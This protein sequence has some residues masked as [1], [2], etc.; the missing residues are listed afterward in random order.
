MPEKARILLISHGHPD[1][2]PGGGEIAAWTL[3]QGYKNRP[4]V[5]K[6]IFLAR[7]GGECAGAIMRHGENEYLW[8]QGLRDGFFM[9]GGNQARAFREFAEFLSAMRPNI[10]H[11]HHAAHMGY[12]IL[13]IIKRVLPEAKIYF[14]LHEYIPICHNDGQMLKKNGGLCFKSGLAACRKCFPEFEEGDF[15]QRKRRFQHFFS[16]VDAFFAPSE[17]LRQRYIQWGLPPEKIVFQENGLRSLPPCP[18]RKL[19]PGGKRGRFG[20]FGQITP[21]KG[22][23]LVLKALSLL[24][25]AER[26]NVSL[27]VH[28]AGFGRVAE[29]LEKKLRRQYGKLAEEGIVRWLGA[30]D[31]SLLAA[32]MEG[33]DWVLLPS[34]WWEN[35]PVVIQEAFACGRPV[36]ASRLGG[37]AEKIRHGADGLLISPCNPQAWAD[38][39]LECSGDNALW[40]RLRAGIR[41]PKGAEEAAAEHLS[42]MDALFESRKEEK[43]AEACGNNAR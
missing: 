19:G 6:A 36:L 34:I 12:E 4:E 25:P 41:P 29:K 40:E 15:W 10:A 11:L 42:K 23:E 20:I 39:M 21:Y 27:E 28:G 18:P 5:E 43:G 1:F 9:E 38:A 30:Y 35:S 24:P 17:F 7:L 2:S 14:T 33:L 32:R 31:P 13:E 22:H 26:A 3:F 37:M 16:L 8:D